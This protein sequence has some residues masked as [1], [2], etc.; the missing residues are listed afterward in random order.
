MRMMTSMTIN[1]LQDKW[2]SI[3]PYSGGFLLVSGDH[4]LSFHIGYF[5]EQMCFMVLDT[6]KRDHINSSKAISADCVQTK[7]QKYALQFLLNYDSLKELFVKLCW[8]LIDCSRGSSKPVDDIIIRFNSWIRLLQKKG[9]G[10]LS[11]SAQKGLIGELLFLQKALK[12]HSASEVTNAWVGPEGSDQDYIFPDRWF[13]IKA[14]TVAAASVTVSSLQ[15]LD[16]EDEGELVVYF[17]DKTTA[18]GV[19]TLSLPQV[20]T[21]IE[22]AL[23]DVQLVDALSC[24][25]AMYGYYYKDAD[26]YR[27]THYRFAGQSSYKVTQDFPKMIRGNVPNAVQNAKYDLALSAIEEYK[28]KGE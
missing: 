6:G 24:K 2:N 9:E 22:H 19:N 21:D 8:D 28:I 5:G 26:R 15:Q 20:V 1:E 7:D 10:L 17:M 4:P 23:N 14:T 12:T 11:S 25:L 27:E 3:S 18:H 13:E 16:R